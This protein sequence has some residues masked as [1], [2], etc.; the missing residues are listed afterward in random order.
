M[1]RDYVGELQDRISDFVG[2][3]LL[4]DTVERVLQKELSEVEFKKVLKYADKVILT[5]RPYSRSQALR[6]AFDWKDTPE[7]YMYWENIHNKLWVKD[8]I[9]KRLLKVRK[10]IMIGAIIVFIVCMYKIIMS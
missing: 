9:Q 10:L 1:K 7:G 5:H 2:K 3:I 4:E 8:K 6:W